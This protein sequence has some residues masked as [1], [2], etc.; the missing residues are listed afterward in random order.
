VAKAT[1]NQKV[2]VIGTVGTISSGAYQRAI[3][4]RDAPALFDLT[5]VECDN[6]R[7]VC[8]TTDPTLDYLVPASRAVL[9][10]VR[11]ANDEAGTTVAGYTHDAGAHVHVFTTKRHA[12]ALRRRLRKVSGVAKVLA[13]APGS[14]GR[15]IRRGLR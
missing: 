15:A 14:G 9:A 13:L 10:E 8:E 3:A 7:L 6:F 11:A 1:R 4:A 5:M 2:G 12:A